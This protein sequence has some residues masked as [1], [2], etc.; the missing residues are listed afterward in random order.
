MLERRNAAIRIAILASLGLPTA[1]SAEVTEKPYNPPTK[2]DEEPYNPPTKMDPPPASPPPSPC[3]GATLVLTS[4]GYYTGFARCPDGTVHRLEPALCSANIPAT[5]CKGDEH[6]KF[7]QT[8]AD[9]THRP[10]GRCVHEES[11]FSTGSTACVC[12]YSC[13]V[14]ADCRADEVC[15]CKDVTAPGSISSCVLA[16]CVQ[17]PDCA[18]GECGL[19]T[20]H[21]G[22]GVDVDVACRT[23]TDA[24]R[25]STDCDADST[26][27]A[28]MSA[29]V[30]ACY[31][32][33]DIICGRPLIV[34]G[35]ARTAP[36]VRRGDWNAVG[37]M[38][39]VRN[40]DPALRAAL[41]EHFRCV[42]ALEH[43]SIASF[44]RFTL[45]LL[46]LG[47][48]PNLIADAQR[49]ALDEV[50]HA[51][52]ACAL[53]SAF[54]GREIGPGPLDVRGV[55]ICSDRSRILAS[56]I[57]EA[58]IGET[59]AAAEAA[60]L[61]PEIVD[62]A[63]RRAYERIAGDELR[64]AVLGWRALAWLLEGAD[65]GARTHVGRLFERAMAAVSRDPSAPPCV[66]P[67][68][69]LPE[70]RELGAIRRAAL[71]EIV[72]P[73]LRRALAG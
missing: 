31:S 46:S 47:A 7:C 62:P 37:V 14:D 36:A 28:P 6:E 60:A 19:S 9:C 3:E 17:N 54:E 70:A 10:Y 45:E 23:A 35:G 13:T 41:G 66:A 8:S 22:C 56:L 32:S 42:A 25:L 30:W 38:P 1:C 64:H 73:S 52:I 68:Y 67:A 20:F 21:Y 71:R 58:C 27:A 69:G 59:L 61:A 33:S 50:E 11:L 57:E 49:A 4:E 34:N 53:A 43:A 65:A 63:L 5:A 55:D 26:C 12:K 15:V 29:P 72:E 44:S 51:Q 40:L 2:M 39:D 18:G 48:P 24:C 16:N